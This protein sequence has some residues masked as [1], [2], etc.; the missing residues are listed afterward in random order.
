MREVSCQNQV[1]LR[2][3]HRRRSGL[4]VAMIFFALQLLALPY[5]KIVGGLLLLWIGVKLL[6]PEDDDHEGIDGGT[7]LFADG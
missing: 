5:L 2:S 4:R 7:T 6:V 1:V 3:F